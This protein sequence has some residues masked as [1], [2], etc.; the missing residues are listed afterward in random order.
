LREALGLWTKVVQF[1]LPRDV[2]IPR[3]S[4]FHPR[5]R[6][7]VLA[8][9]IPHKARWRPIH[10]FPASTIPVA[11]TDDREYLCFCQIKVDQQVVLP[12]L[13]RA[14][15]L[16]VQLLHVGSGRLGPGPA[17]IGE[18]TRAHLRSQAFCVQL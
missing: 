7:T 15:A 9:H 5:F 1:A 3:C 8:L 2:Q 4:A 14:L 12:D 10:T 16:L 11:T 6:R 17:S 18:I 13:H